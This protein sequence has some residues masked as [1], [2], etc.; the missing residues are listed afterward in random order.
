MPETGKYTVDVVFKGASKKKSPVAGAKTEGKSYAEKTASS[1][2][3]GIKGLVSF[4]AISSTA[5][6]LIAYKYNTVELR[7]GAAELEQRQ[8]Y[9]FDRVSEGITTGV[10]IGVGAAT[11]NLPLVLIGL[12]STGIN[13]LI[14]IAQRTDI[15]LQKQN[16]ESVG[17]R[18]SNIR[19][20][21]G[22]RRGRDQ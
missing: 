13:K 20:G 14:E 15:L 11:G 9:I 7:T 22:G 4:R 6:T 1:L 10:A 2:D 18:M 19:A 16:I 21:V 3:R 5:R 12:V 8:S 17:I